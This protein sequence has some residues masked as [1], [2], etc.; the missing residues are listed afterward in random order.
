MLLDLCTGGYHDRVLYGVEAPK[1]AIVRR[2]AARVVQQFLRC[3]SS[4]R[5]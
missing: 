5:P 4:T 3:Y 2:E 1:T